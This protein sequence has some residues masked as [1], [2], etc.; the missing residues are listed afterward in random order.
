MLALLLQSP[1]NKYVT[2]NSIQNELPYRTLYAAVSYQ[3]ARRD[4]IKLHELKLVKT[5]ENTFQLDRN[6]LNAL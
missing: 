6:I 4:L 3:T 1:A 2:I 5:A